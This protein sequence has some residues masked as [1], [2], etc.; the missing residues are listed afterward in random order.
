MMVMIIG[1]S[2]MFQN[3]TKVGSSMLCIKG[4]YSWFYVTRVNDGGDDYCNGND[5]DDGNDKDED[6]LMGT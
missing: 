1:W 5:G 4:D 3:I 6:D 2:I